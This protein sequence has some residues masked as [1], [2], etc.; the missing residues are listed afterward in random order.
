[1]SIQSNSAPSLAIV[2]FGMGNL[3]SI[4]KALERLGLEPVVTA[5]PEVLA[6]AH[7]IVLPGDGAFGDAVKEMTARGIIDVVRDRAREAAN[8]GRP[9]LGI[10]IGMQILVETSDEDPGITGLA[11]IQGHCPRIP[12]SAGLK[13]PHMGW[14]ALEISDEAC[15]L[16]DGMPEGPYVYFVHAYHVE[17]IDDSVVAARAEYGLHVAAVLHRN[18]LFATQFHPEKSQGIGLRLLENFGRVAAQYTNAN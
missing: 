16:F 13:V 5:D 17:P 6:S 3:H 9:F 10:C 15:P 18:N 7:S 14:N 8:G 12:A 4:H 1:L 2:D 11:V